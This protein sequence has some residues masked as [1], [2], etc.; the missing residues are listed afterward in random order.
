MQIHPLLIQ[1]GDAKEFVESLK[2]MIHESFEIGQDIGL[3][4]V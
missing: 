1:E 3:F 2:H 4:C